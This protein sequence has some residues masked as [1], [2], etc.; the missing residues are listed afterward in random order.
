MRA[1]SIVLLLAS[2]L[3]CG[4][5]ADNAE[6]P[7]SHGIG[8][9]PALPEPSQRGDPDH[10]LC[11]GADRMAHGRK[12][13]R[14]PR[15][16]ASPRSHR[17]RPS[18]LAAMFCRTATCWSPRPTRSRSPAKSLRD[19]VQK[20]AQR[21]AG[22]ADPERRPH[23]AAAR[24]RRRR[25]RRDTN[26]LRCSDLTSP[27]G[28]ALVGDDLYVANTDALLRFP[29]RAGRDAHCRARRADRGAAGGRDQPSLDQGPRRERRRTHALRLG[30]VEQRPCRERDRGR[31]AGAP[32]SGRST[33]RRARPASSP[34]AC[35][36]RS[37][38]ISSRGPA[39][40]GPPSTS[41]TS[42][43]ATSSPTT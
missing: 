4:A 27:F 32:Q 13:R 18:S 22:A 28:M 38:W 41:A 8:P 21:I 10:Q 2:T 20:Q 26:G 30:R 15:A 5:C 33:Q 40:S 12:R 24:R 35:A 9:D 37:A 25:G 23:L 42:S 11:A 19:V 1:A 7:V 34:R 17:P 29:Y 14:R 39:R 16:C 31:G 6:L 43:A 3:V 36:I